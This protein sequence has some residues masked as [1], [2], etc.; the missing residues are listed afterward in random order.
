MVCLP[1]KIRD[2]ADGHE[3]GRKSNGKFDYE[4]SS[5]ELDIRLFTV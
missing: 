1:K 5:P 2:I 4:W 3:D